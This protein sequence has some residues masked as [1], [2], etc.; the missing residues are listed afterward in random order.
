M[1]SNSVPAEAVQ[2]ATGKS[3]EEWLTILDEAGAHE[4]NHKQ[5]VAFLSTN[6]SDRVSDWWQQSLTVGYEKARGKRILGQTADAGFQ[7]GVQKTL[8]LA[9]DA[10][11]RF[12]LSPEGLK[13]WLPVEGELE[14]EPK[15][16]F[17]TQDGTSGEIRSIDPGKRLRLTW[18]PKDWQ[19]SST[20]QMYLLSGDNATTSL[21]FHH[22]KLTSLAVRHEMKAYWQAALLRIEQAVRSST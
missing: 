4:W 11:W 17:T 19:K 3:W 16:T 10:L 6:Y 8:P 5:I 13:L 15:Q 21:R 22:E 18:Q 20:L 1:E 9:S 12:L 2:R 14:L 7:V